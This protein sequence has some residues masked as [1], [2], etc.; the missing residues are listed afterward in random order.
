MLEVKNRFKIYL[1]LFDVLIQILNKQKIKCFEKF[2]L[3]G[4]RR[5]SVL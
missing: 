5:F 4:I 2:K 1:K 3:N